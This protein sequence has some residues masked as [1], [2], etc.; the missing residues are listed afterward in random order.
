MKKYS[1][2]IV[3]FGVACVAT[4]GQVCAKSDLSFVDAQFSGFLDR[5][6]QKNEH[7]EFLRFFTTFTQR[8]S[9]KEQDKQEIIRTELFTKALYYLKRDKT[10]W[11]ESVNQCV[12]EGKERG[13]QAGDDLQKVQIFLSRYG[14]YMAFLETKAKT[15]REQRPLP[16]FV[17]KQFH[18]FVAY[19]VP[20]KDQERF[21]RY[22]TKVMGEITKAGEPMKE[23]TLA[24]LSNR[25]VAA[26]QAERVEWHNAIQPYLVDK[27][28]FV[29]LFL[30]R[31]GAYQEFLEIR[32]L[33]GQSESDGQ[34][35]FAS[36]GSY[37]SNVGTTI[38]GWFGFGQTQ[39]A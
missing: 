6:V 8:F 12:A 24:Y 26:L 20:Q 25:A 9:A 37:F 22:Y 10:P 38:A 23:A 33:R 30:Q 1:N 11:Y 19:V 17:K 14:A 34:G 28:E 3:L 36:I 27:N 29:Q 21:T 32:A 16:E 2:F 5:V 13:D 18:D 35:M 39:A 4:A 15:A 7:D 31:Y